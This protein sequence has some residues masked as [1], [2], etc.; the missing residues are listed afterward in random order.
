MSLGMSI[1]RRLT[2]L[3]LI[4]CLIAAVPVFASETGRYAL[5]LANANYPGK[6]RSLTNPVRDA[7]LMERTL[8]SLG[9]T[10]SKAI[11]LTRKGMI[12]AVADFSAQLPVGSVALV[13]Y[14]GHGVQVANQNYLLPVD[15]EFDDPAQV[16]L[17]SLPLQ[18]VLE[19]LAA[20]SSNVNVVVLDACRNN[21][22]AGSA[23]GKYRNWTPSPDG[24]ATVLAPRGTLVAY[25]TAPGELAA[26]GLAR[27]S[28]YTATLASLLLRPGLPLDQ[29]FKQVANTVRQKTGNAQQPWYESSLTNDVVLQTEVHSTQTKVGSEQPVVGQSTISAAEGNSTLPTN[30]TAGAMSREEW[31]RRNVEL[32]LRVRNF[33]PDEIKPTEQRARRGDVDSMVLLGM[34]YR[35]MP[36]N[37][38]AVFWYER[39]AAKGD[40]IAQTELGEMRYFG[41]GGRKDVNEAQRLFERAAAQGYPGAAINLAQLKMKQSPSADTQREFL[42]QTGYPDPA[43]LLNLL[44]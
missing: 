18:T 38:Q 28:L 3:Y 9:F 2:R 30:R 37:T 44:K 15:A 26:D 7:D 31:R 32:D 40:A 8:K 6:T 13:Y 25:S 22:F 41:E 43:V 39:A 24:L 14:A 23:Q 35:A 16:P 29:V 21:P 17:R 20:T 10:V 19:R 1:K 42:K 11:N 33:S 5:V 34:V 36:N 12:S 4:L 27:N